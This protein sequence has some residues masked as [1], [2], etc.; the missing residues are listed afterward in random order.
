MEH[1]VTLISCLQDNDKCVLSINDSIASITSLFSYIKT[2]YP[3]FEI[4]NSHIFPVLDINQF[5]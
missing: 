3:F 4:F 2:W 1:G 5:H